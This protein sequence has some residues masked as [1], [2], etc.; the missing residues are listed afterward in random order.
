VPWS[1]TYEE[2]T[3]GGLTPEQIVRETIDDPY[4][5]EPEAYERQMEATIAF[6]SRDRLDRITAPTLL[7]F[8]E[9][10]LYTP[11]RFARSMHERIRE[12][13]LVVL[14]GAGHALLR[15]RGPEVAALIDGFLKETP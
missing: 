6:Q 4:F 10:D 5:Q 8:G 7:V 12:S 15:T 3:F 13:R 14:S 1:Y 11:V 2:L 9:D